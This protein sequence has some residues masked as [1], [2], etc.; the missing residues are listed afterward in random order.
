M[1]SPGKHQG[2]E[3][4]YH[5]S[6]FQRPFH[7]HSAE[8]KQ[9]HYERTDIDGAVCS[10]GIA[11]IGAEI[12]YILLLELTVIARGRQIAEPGGL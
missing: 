10:L 4:E 3:G 5:Q 11:E 7:H 1:T 8:Q 9:S 12:L 2:E 6:P